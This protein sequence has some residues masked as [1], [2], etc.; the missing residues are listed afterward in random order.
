[1]IKIGA[2]VETTGQYA[3]SENDERS[4]GNGADLDQII[5]HPLK[6]II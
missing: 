5:S 3:N 1:L 2:K 4:G 6:V